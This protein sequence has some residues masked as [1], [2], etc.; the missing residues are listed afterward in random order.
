MVPL[1]LFL[2][3]LGTSF[4]KDLSLVSW[5]CV[6]FFVSYLVGQPT[7]IAFSKVRAMPQAGHIVS[8]WADTGKL[9]MFGCKEVGEKMGVRD[10]ALEASF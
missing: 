7:E 6:S 4:L 8:T 9:H 1:K 2:F 5:L 10:Q 3:F